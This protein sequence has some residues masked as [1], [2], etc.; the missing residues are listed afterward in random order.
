MSATPEDLQ[1]PRT[2]GS[3]SVGSLLE[4]ILNHTGSEQCSAA[5]IVNPKEL[6]LPRTVGSYS[7][8]P[9]MGHFW[10]TF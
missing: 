8:T 1:L 6:K 10:N 2:V 3:R 5:L 7:V 4:H 9:S